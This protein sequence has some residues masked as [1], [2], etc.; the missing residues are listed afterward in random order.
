[1]KIKKLCLA[2]AIAMLLSLLAACGP[3]P[4]AG[5]T[6]DFSETD[7]KISYRIFAPGL[8]DFE[9]LENDRVLKY[10]ESKFN[11]SLNISGSAE[12]HWRTRLNNEVYDGDTPDL[13]FSIP[14]ESSY[15]DLIRRE[16][17]TD[18]NPYI[19]KLDAKNLKAVLDSEQYKE[20]TKLNGKNYFLPQSTGVSNHTLYV[21]KD[22]MRKWNEDSV[23]NGGR[24]KTGDEVYDHPQTLSDF[25]SMLTYF[26]LKDPDGDK[27]NNTYGLSL[28]NNFDFYKDFMGTFGVVP[29]YFRDDNGDIQLSVNTENYQ[30]MI[31][32]FKTGTSEGYV[33]PDYFL[34]TEDENRLSFFQGRVGAMISNGD[35]I[36]AGAL[37]E[38]RALN[39]D[40][41]MDM[42]D[43]L[44]M[45]DSDDGQY[46]GAYKGWNFF[47]GG[48][49]VSADAPEPMRLVKILD[50]LISAEGQ[51]L[52]VYGVEGIH[53]NKDANGKAVSNNANRLSD[54]ISVFEFPDVRKPQE[55]SGRYKIG[56]VLLPVPFIIQDGKL[57]RNYPFD[58]SLSPEML[59][60][61]YD[62]VD[63]PNAAAPNFSALKNLIGDPAVNDRH[64]RIMDAVRIYT[65]NV[66]AGKSAENELN[67]LN[68]K[69]TANDVD[70]VLAYIKA[71]N[72]L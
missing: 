65:I 8:Q 45:P 50:Y 24:G 14:S 1:M 21:R 34:Q 68:Q 5:L 38:F 72:G 28:P 18:L 40:G 52:L 35:G 9:N 41:Y 42:L 12:A 19:E 25:T 2:M 49:S 32:W 22:W 67:T 64:N 43:I 16:V 27:T 69:L 33:Y 36:V 13:F 47:W 70:G 15:T 37:T 7:K 60:K 39:P 48:F 53:Y 58:T 57:A 30:T 17:I 26:A 4:S 10:L 31:D 6:Y 66:I 46:K 71:N 51:E 55:P 3:E 23:A 62:M 59:E 61:S 56:Y 44:P 11:V 29:D 20:T 63:G 54:G